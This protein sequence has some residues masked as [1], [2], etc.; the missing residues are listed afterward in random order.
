MYA[1]VYAKGLLKKEAK[2]IKNLLWTVDRGL[3]TF[4]KNLLRKGV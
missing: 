1:N 4:F 3:W 2:T